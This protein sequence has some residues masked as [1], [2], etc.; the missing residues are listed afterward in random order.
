MRKIDPYPQNQFEFTKDDQQ[1]NL[2]SK[3]SASTQK[4]I[5]PH[6]FQEFYIEIT[7]TTVQQVTNELSLSILQGID[8]EKDL[9]YVRFADIGGHCIDL[10][11]M[12][13][14]NTLNGKSRQIYYE[15]PQG[16]KLIR[17]N[18]KAQISPQISNSKLIY[19][20]FYW[21]EKD[22][23]KFKL[24]QPCISDIIEN[25]YQTYCQTSRCIYEF[26]QQQ[27]R[28]I[29]DFKQNTL[30]NTNT[31]KINH[32]QR[33]NIKKPYQEIPKKPISR[34][35]LKEIVW[36]YQ[37]QPKSYEWN[38][39]DEQNKDGLE[40]AYQKYCKNSQKANTLNVIRN[41]SKYYIDFDK[42]IEY[43]LFTKESRQIRRFLQ[44]G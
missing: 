38:N 2:Q 8:Q 9:I 11:N 10:I 28:F 35:A 12:R 5:N 37:L 1:N 16:R 26:T 36:Q 6:Q 39:Y 18:H 21:F 24:L 19:T 40:K 33:R 7:P 30:E 27:H 20:Q 42:M 44:E 15:V 32:I 29:V 41:T 14:I 25:L 22:N 13:L 31:L 17:L 4:T 3:K 34:G 43:N 23:S